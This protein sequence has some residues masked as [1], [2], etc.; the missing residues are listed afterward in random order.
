MVKRFLVFIAFSSFIQF[1]Y[2]QPLSQFG[3]SPDAS[4]C[5]IERYVTD[6]KRVG[7]NAV[8]VSVNILF[9]IDY[10]DEQDIFPLIVPNAEKLKVTG[11]S[12]RLCDIQGVLVHKERI[13]RP[14]VSQ[15]LK[16]NPRSFISKYV[17]ESKPVN[18]ELDY[19]LLVINPRGDYDWPA[20][21]SNVCSIDEALL[22]LNY[23]NPDDF[24]FNSNMVGIQEDDIKTGGYYYLWRIKKLTPSG[25]EFNGVNISTPFVKISLK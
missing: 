2:S 5:K 7:E 17:A 19:R 14:T 4:P 10:V 12:V 9:Y 6:V 11:C 25:G 13:K 18:V 20:I 24:E 8:E 15:L 21:S 22:R 1:L 16:F 23:E 3:I